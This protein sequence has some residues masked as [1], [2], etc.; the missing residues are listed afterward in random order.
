[1]RGQWLGLG[2][3]PEP[4]QGVSPVSPAPCPFCSPPQIRPLIPRWLWWE[5]GRARKLQSRH[6]GVDLW[7]VRGCKSCLSVC[8]GRVSRDKTML[9]VDL[10]PAAQGLDQGRD[11]D[12]L[13]TLGPALTLP[14]L[15]SAAAC[16]LRQALTPLASV[17][18]RAHEHS[19]FLH[20]PGP[21]ESVWGG[22]EKTPGP[23]QPPGDCSSSTKA[24]KGPPSQASPRSS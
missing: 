24:L 2:Q 11:R 21:V 4:I 8:R 15:V 12:R 5:A 16:D 20:L 22:K 9:S 1:M 23:Q 17:A 13:A 3:V 18:P 19:G 14:G 10:A 6:T 7:A